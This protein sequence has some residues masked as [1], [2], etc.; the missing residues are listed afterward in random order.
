[1]ESSMCALTDIENSMKRSDGVSALQ[2]DIA[3]ELAGRVTTLATSLEALHTA[4]S[5]SFF[6]LPPGE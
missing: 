1:L 5:H 2:S 6:P 3:T 4:G